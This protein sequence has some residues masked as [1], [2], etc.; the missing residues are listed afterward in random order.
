MANLIDGTSTIIASS[1]EIRFGRMLA[2]A[3]T[4]GVT[5][6]PATTLEASSPL[7]IIVDATPGLSE[8]SV[9]LDGS[10][11]IST[12][13]TPGKYSIKTI[14]PQKSGV[15]AIKIN[16]KDSLG[17]SKSTDSP[18]SLTV[19]EKLTAPT[20]PPTFKNVKTTTVGDRITFDFAV[21][22]APLDLTSFKI[23]YGKNA[24]SLSQEVT[25]LPID[26]IASKMNSG[27]Y[28]WYIDSLPTDTYTFKIF[29]RTAS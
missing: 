7:E 4:Y 14:T 23:A 28:I 20:V 17:Q 13:T 12:E 2:A 10:I 26:K 5:L 6:L 29:G 19:T 21:D 24:D 15:Y 18:T 11:L 22:N 25:T 9:S 16:Q 8:I 3:A 27:S 1:P